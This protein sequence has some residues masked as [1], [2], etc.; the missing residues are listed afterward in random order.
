MNIRMRLFLVLL[1]S[2]CAAGG[3]SDMQNK[4]NKKDR[5]ELTLQLQEKYIDGQAQAALILCQHNSCLNPLHNA[6]G[7]EFYFQDHAEAYN[8]FTQKSGI[9]EKVK[10]ALLGIAAVTGTASIILLI[11][12]GLIGKKLDKHF[13]IVE[14]RADVSLPTDPK[15]RQDMEKAKNAYPPVNKTKEPTHHVSS[16]DGTLS[17]EQVKKLNDDSNWSFGAGMTAASIGAVSWMTAFGMELS[18]SPH[19]RRKQ[20]DFEK[21]FVQGERITVNKQELAV[22][23]QVMNEKLGVRVAPNVMRFLHLR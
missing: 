13:P 9:G 11:R 10:F 3:A 5:Q 2:A 1:T 6:D 21:L 14:G 17:E 18:T 12:H 20:K 16:G 23:L 22:L 4:K 15:L 7:S 8:T 19:W